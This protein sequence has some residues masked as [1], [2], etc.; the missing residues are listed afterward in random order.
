[1][2]TIKVTHPSAGEVVHYTNEKFPVFIA[3]ERIKQLYGKSV[4]SKCKI[5]VIEG[6]KI[7]ITKD[8][9]VR[10]KLMEQ[11]YKLV[12]F[13]VKAT[14]WTYWEILKDVRGNRRRFEKL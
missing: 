12:K 9:G 5:E 8:L 3:L 14:G 1:M 4:Y 7:K 6:D 2:P 10:D 11:D 13:A